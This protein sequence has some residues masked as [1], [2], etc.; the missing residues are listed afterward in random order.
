M[1]QVLFRVL[2]ILVSTPGGSRPRTFKKTVE[3]CKKRVK[4][5]KRVKEFE[6][7]SESV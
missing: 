2:S 7:T 3:T 1:T 4:D 6:R 5:L